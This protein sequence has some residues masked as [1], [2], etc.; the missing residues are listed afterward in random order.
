MTVAICGRV[1]EDQKPLG[2]ARRD[3]LVVAILGADI[4][5]RPAREPVVRENVVELGCIVAREKDVVPMEREA[6]RLCDD[7]PCH[8]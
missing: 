3:I 8:G 6:I 1:D 5:R 7:A 4:D 2:T